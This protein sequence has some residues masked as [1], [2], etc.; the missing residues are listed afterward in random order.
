MCPPTYFDV[1]YRIN[2]WMDPGT[3]VDHELAGRQWQS[4]VDAFRG[5]GH[6]VHLIDPVA[7][8]PDM[9][10]VTDSGTVVDGVALGARYR[11]EHRAPEADHVL[12]WFEAN[13]LR[14]AVRPRYINEGGGDF[15]VVGEMIFAGTGFRTDERAHAEAEWAFGKRVVTLRLVDPHYYHLNTAMGVLDD[16][17]VAYLPS[18]FD[19]RSVTVLRS[20]FPDAVIATEADT[21]WLALNLVSDGHNVVMAAQAT[22]LAA[23]LRARGYNPVPVDMSEFLKSGGGIRCCTLELRGWRP[24]GSQP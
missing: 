23:Q 20:L 5:L 2:D 18:A 21:R 8:L 9:V 13:G 19:E 24:P 15:L 11:S 14:R 22:A 17:T 1:A 12:R 4:L 3:P 16:R 7:G 6:R 10:F